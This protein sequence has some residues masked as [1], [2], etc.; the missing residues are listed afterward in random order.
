[1]VTLSMKDGWLIGRIQI[2]RSNGRRDRTETSATGAGRFEK[3]PFIYRKGDLHRTVSP[4]GD[5]LI[6]MYAYVALRVLSSS[7]WLRMRNNGWNRPGQRAW[8][9][10]RITLTGKGETGLPDGVFTVSWQ[11]GVVFSWK[12]RVLVTRGG[13]LRRCVHP[14]RKWALPQNRAAPLSRFSLRPMESPILDTIHKDA[15]QVVHL[16]AKDVHGPT[17][18]LGWMRTRS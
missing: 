18:G 9:A 5:A 17:P 6:V 7:G 13:R 15:C 14:A 16:V 8:G 12:T 11:S 10:S 4:A 1:M 2:G 3:C